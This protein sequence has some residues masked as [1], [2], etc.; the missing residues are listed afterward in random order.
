MEMVGLEEEKLEDC[1]EVVKKER[2]KEVE[3]VEFL[4][5]VRVA[6]AAVPLEADRVVG[7]ISQYDLLQE[8]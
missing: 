7:K 3:T 5:E 1:W 6:T 8:A 4:E 2:E